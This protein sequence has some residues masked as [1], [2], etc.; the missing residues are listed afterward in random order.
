MRTSTRK[1]YYTVWKD[2]VKVN[3]DGHSGNHTNHWE[4]RETVDDHA[5]K[6]GGGVYT[7]KQPDYEIDVEPPESGHITCFNVPVNVTV[8]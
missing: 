3:R 8:L 5:D 4:A 6:N 7:I 2:G 1:G